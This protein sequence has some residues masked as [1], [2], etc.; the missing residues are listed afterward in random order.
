MLKRLTQNQIDDYRRDGFVHPVEVMSGEE[1]DIIRERL[2][3]MER[4]YPNEVNPENRNNAHLVFK[5]LD[6]VAHHR[7]ILDAV[8]DLI[9]QNILV[10]GSVL[11]IKEPQT[12]AFVSWHQDMTYPSLHPHDG[13]T[14]WLA[15]TASNRESGCVQMMPGSHHDPIR[16][17]HDRYGE[18]NILTRGQTIEG[19]DETQAVNVVL[20]P[21][22]MSLHHG[23]TIHGSTPN[24]SSERRIGIA[25]Q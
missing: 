16:V 5:C 9:G 23:R 6:G 24:R 13:V 15:L 7:V 10:W 2:E 11:F 4:R 19:L 17:H 18:H 22:Q 14:A 12:K 8:E 25:I 21:G 1:A 3:D 20:E